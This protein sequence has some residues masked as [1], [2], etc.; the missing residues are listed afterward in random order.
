MCEELFLAVIVSF[1]TYLVSAVYFSNGIKIPF[2]SALVINVFS[3]A[4]LGSTLLFSEKISEFLPENICRISGTAVLCAIGLLTVFKSILREISRKIS[5]RGEVM[6]KN[7][8]GLV[9]K[10]YLD[11]T[12]ADTDNSKVL[13]AKESIALAVASSCD[14][15]GIGIGS[16]LS[17]INPFTVSIFTFIAGFTAIFLGNLTGRKLGQMKYDLSWVGGILLIIFAFL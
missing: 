6:L 16:G 5:Q 13:S 12:S 4:I 7:R 15:A 9:I 1:D 11:E 2:V 14:S 10:L 17:G 3:A 8:S